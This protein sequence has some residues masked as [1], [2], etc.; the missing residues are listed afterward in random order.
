MENNNLDTPEISFRE[1]Y[2]HIRHNYITIVCSMIIVC[3][4]V[5]LYL[6]IINPSY[7]AEGTIIIEEESS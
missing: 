3:T 4:L 6:F 2:Y 5:A 1:L 7:T